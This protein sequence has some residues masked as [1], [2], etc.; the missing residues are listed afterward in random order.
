MFAHTIAEFFGHILFSFTRSVAEHYN[1]NEDENLSDLFGY[2]ALEDTGKEW[3]CQPVDEVIYQEYSNSKATAM[4]YLTRSRL[5]ASLIDA[6]STEDNKETEGTLEDTAMAWKQFRPSIFRTV[7]SSLYFGFFI[8]V[9]SATILGIISVLVY[10]LSYETV[11]N[12]KD[13]YKL[14]SISIKLQWVIT[15]SRVIS[16][17]FIYHWFFLN[18]LFYFRPFQISGV[19]LRLFLLSLLPFCLDSAYTIALQPV[20]ISIANSKLRT[21]LL[22][23]CRI[24]FYI[25]VCLQIYITARHFCKR[26]A[27]K[28]LKLILLFLIPCVLTNVTADLIADFVYP[29][30]T[31]QDKNGK[32]IIAIFA[33]LIT[34]FLKGASRICVQRSWCR[35]SHP[36]TS[37]VLLVPLYYESA[38]MVRLLQVDLQSLESVALIGVIHGI[39]EVIER[40]SMVLIDHFYNQVL[41]K[42]RI[43]LGGFRTPRRERLATDI[44]IMSMLCESSAV[45]SVNGLLHLYQYFYTSDNSP[46]QLLQSFV[47]TTSAPLVIEWLF[48]SVSIAIETRYQNMPIMAVWRKQWKRHII[49]AAINLTIIS[50]WSA[51]YLLTG[52]QERFTNIFQDHCKM[53]FT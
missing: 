36:G 4:D 18:V 17:G 44:C 31:R 6:C 29:A 10:Y 8:S 37:F 48:T 26:P 15:I 46:P 13:L 53:P 32:V 39:A 25:S 21:T 40:S 24:L 16:I 20:G 11:L 22:I 19:K 43:P 30:Y 49:V 35:I 2:N 52:V 51:S 38:V 33:P 34:V 3:Y 47:I 12:C 23:P 28:Q 7:S 14:D 5:N 42:R 50:I 1:F 41:E 45:I 27:I 9:L